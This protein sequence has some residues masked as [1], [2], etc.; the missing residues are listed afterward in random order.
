[1]VNILKCHLVLG[2]RRILNIVSGTFKC[3][4]YKHSRLYWYEYLNFP[5]VPINSVT[6][7]KENFLQIRPSGSATKQPTFNCGSICNKKQ[8]W[9]ED[10][11]HIYLLSVFNPSWGRHISTHCQQGHIP[12]A[13]LR[14][15]LVPGRCLSQLHRCLALI[16]LF[17]LPTINHFLFL[18]CIN[19]F[20][21]NRFTYCI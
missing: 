19:R 12:T 3:I 14:Q 6:A 16:S 13:A 1:M 11:L 10:M 5:L 17:S 18:P 4:L 7:G 20:I 9:C 21:L 15:A 8:K 2:S